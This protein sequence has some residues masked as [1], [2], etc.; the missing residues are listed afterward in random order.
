M[1][2]PECAL[3]R[4]GLIGIYTVESLEHLLR[5]DTRQTLR[6][7]AVGRLGFK[8]RAA[9]QTRPHDLYRPPD[10]CPPLGIG[11]SEND[12]CRQA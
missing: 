7:I 8:T 1:C 6:I 12:C 9:L 4:D 2:K 3:F 10:R 5:T 11:R